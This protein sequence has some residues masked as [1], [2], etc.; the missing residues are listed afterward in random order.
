MENETKTNEE[1]N[2]QSK[3]A[4]FIAFFHGK[5]DNR[6]V[7]NMAITFNDIGEITEYGNVK[8]I[9]IYLSKDFINPKVINFIPLRKS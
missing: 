6:E 4:Y 8:S 9:E 2:E 3:F 1:G 7:E 5:S